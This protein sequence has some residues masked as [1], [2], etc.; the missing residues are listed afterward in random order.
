M[1]LWFGSDEA[2]ILWEGSD[3]VATL[4]YGDDEVFDAGAAPPA[5]AVAVTLGQWSPGVS[6]YGFA[7]SP[8]PRQ[9]GALAPNPVGGVTWNAVMWGNLGAGTV[10]RLMRVSAPS[11]TALSAFPASISLESGGT[12][13][14]ATRQD[15]TLATRAGGSQQV[16]YLFTDDIFSI[17]Q[18]VVTGGLITVTVGATQNLTFNF[19]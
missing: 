7:A 5:G 18:N 13:Y 2:E 11:G 8:I 4:W 10:T 15:G 12:T 6:I 19:E 14:T 9:F 17:S 16:D 1:T 3:E